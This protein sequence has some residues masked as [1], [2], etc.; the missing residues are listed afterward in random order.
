MLAVQDIKIVNIEEEEY[1]HFHTGE[2]FA[3]DVIDPSDKMM[4]STE[5]VKGM[6]FR[7]HRGQTICIG[8]TRAVQEVIGLPMG[9]FDEQRKEISNLHVEATILNATI[10]K[11]RNMN[12]WG[13]VKFLFKK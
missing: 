3:T 11:Y 1:K 5:I 12:F 4:V 8:M 6:Q 7:N 2:L 10:Y 13:R 9:A